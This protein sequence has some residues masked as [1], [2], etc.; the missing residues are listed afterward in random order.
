MSDKPTSLTMPPVGAAPD[1]EL[2][3][4]DLVGEYEI[5]GTLGRG[6]FGTVFEAAHPLIGKRAAIKVLARRFSVD[7]EMVSRFVAEARAVNQ[8]RHRHIIDI[9]AFGQLPDGRHYYVM[10]LLEGETL[11]VA[12]EAVG[13]FSLA[14]AID[15]LRGIAKALD[16]AHAKGIAHRDLKAE[17]VFL[18]REGEER[19]PKLLDFGIAKL[20]SPED[21]LKHKT[22][23]GAPIGTPYYMSPEQ[24]RGRD[25]DH[26]TDLYAF[27]VLAYLL[28][29]GAYPFDADDFMSILFQQITA[30]PPKPSAAV[31]EL[32]AAVDDAIHALMAK[33]PADRPAT[34]RAAVRMLEAAAGFEVPV[35]PLSEPHSVSSVVAA[36][37][38]TPS[39]IGTAADAVPEPVDDGEAAESRGGE[40][41]D[42]AG[43][44]APRRRAMLVA[45]MIGGAALA[46]IAVVLA[47]HAS[48][49]GSTSRDAIAREP[50]RA[51]VVAA[52][53]VAAP[54][55]AA[56]PGAPM[57]A[58]AS[59]AVVAAPGAPMPAVPGVPPE[60]VPSIIVTVTGVPEGTEVRIGSAS[61]GVAP[62]PVQVPRGEGAVVLTFKADGF[63][64]QAKT[65]T[66]DHDQGVSIM[67]K[68]KAHAPAAPRPGRDDLLD[69]F[70]KHR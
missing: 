48:G 10:E 6:A 11:D 12:L 51:A 55:P 15:I 46:A 60:A 30:A 57:P 7:P 36:V 40:A 21:G 35:G 37:T 20:M 27:G 32:P 3:A 41:D 44:P 39:M 45:A 16:A 63:V 24:C 31:P 58:P 23:T 34:A 13:R 29:T 50:G 38:P 1:P 47:V 43:A 64:P 59:A 61:V 67:L 5:V 28:L 2:E 49:G 9:F 52:P 33:D 54:M 18:A 69:P 19:W 62:G 53:I 56:A 70:G 68:P 65:L 4:G 25:V 22:R 8:I 26:R 14:G 17:N 42:A 66:P